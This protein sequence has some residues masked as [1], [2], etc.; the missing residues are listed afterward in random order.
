MK[1]NSVKI[2]SILNYLSTITSWSLFVILIFF[3][4]ILAYYYVTMRLYAAKG[5]K[6]EPAFSIYTIV[7][8]SMVPNIKVYDVIVNTKVDEPTEIQVGDVITFKSTSSLTRGMTITHRVTAVE[9]IDGK[10]QFITK[11]DNNPGPDLSPALY[12]NII[13][14]TLFRIPS[15]GR[16]Q[17]FVASK[18]GWLVVVILPALYIVFKDVLKLM[19]ITKTKKIAEEVN[20]RLRKETELQKAADGALQFGKEVNNPLVEDTDIK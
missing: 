8:P 10:Y 20:E 17:I 1:R 18:F 12:E 6:Y 3:A 4:C 2:K 15:L 19:R 14:K 9:K 5:D 7:S 11:G 16:V 13:G